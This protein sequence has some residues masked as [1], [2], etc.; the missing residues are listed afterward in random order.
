MQKLILF[1]IA[2]GWFTF[3]SANAQSSTIMLLD[4]KANSQQKLPISIKFIPAMK[5]KSMP[6]F[7]KIENDM[8]VYKK[9]PFKFRLGS[10]AQTDYLEQKN[11][12]WIYNNGQH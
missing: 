5:P 1:I 8:I 9:I 7:C 6:L 10:V 3:N 2:L 4:L 12:Y 11:G